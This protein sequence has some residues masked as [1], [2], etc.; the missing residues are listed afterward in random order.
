MRQADDM[1][2]PPAA[3]VLRALLE[4][5][6][7]FE[8]WR[9]IDSGCGGIGPVVMAHR[10]L[11]IPLPPEVAAWVAASPDSPAPFDDPVGYPWSTNPRVPAWQRAKLPS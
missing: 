1:A 6:M 9:Q 11:S 2:T 5:V 4:A 10:A 8:H 3:D 7:G